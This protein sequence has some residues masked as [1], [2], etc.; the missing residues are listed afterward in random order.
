MDL[1]TLL[2]QF[3]FLVICQSFKYNVYKI[4]FQRLVEYTNVPNV[5]SLDHEWRPQIVGGDDSHRVIPYQISLQ[6]KVKARKSNFMDEENMQWRHNC[7]I[8][9]I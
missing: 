4:P 9:F 8:F 2:F 3:T 5:M 7:V 1:Q 6:V